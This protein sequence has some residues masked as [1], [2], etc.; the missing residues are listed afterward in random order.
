MPIP[1]IY[2]RVKPLIGKIW[3]NILIKCLA[4][5]FLHKTLP[6]V[7]I[8]STTFVLCITA[9]GDENIF[10][11]DFSLQGKALQFLLHPVLVKSDASIVQ[12]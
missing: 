9:F 7:F 8:L 12:K 1:R 3:T 11:G 2:P 6:I 4:K 10:P 5:W